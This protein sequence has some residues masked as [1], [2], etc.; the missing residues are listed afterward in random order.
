MV[1]KLF[2]S[3]SLLNFDLIKSL[4]SIPLKG[5]TPKTDSYAI[6]PREYMSLLSS[7]NSPL[8]NSGA[9]YSNV[10]PISLSDTRSFI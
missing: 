10:P 5:D 4:M 2:L 6:I 1:I 8:N 9:I 7:G 3:I